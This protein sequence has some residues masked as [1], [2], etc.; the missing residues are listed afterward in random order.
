ML[1]AQG[2]SLMICSNCGLGYIETF[3]QLTGLGPAVCDTENPGRTGLTKAENI[4]LLLRRNE[5]DRALYLG[6]TAGDQAAAAGA[7]IPFVHA[8]Y[9]FGAVPDAAPAVCIAH[10]VRCS[11][12][13]FGN[14]RLG[15]KTVLQ[16]LCTKQSSVGLVYPS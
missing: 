11:G 12:G 2:L 5:I 4:K 1:R 8:A 10:F 7:G 6:D 15:I 3:L 9:G 13:F 14:A 16:V